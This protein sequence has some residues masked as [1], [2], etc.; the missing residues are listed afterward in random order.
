MLKKQ[1]VAQPKQMSDERLGSLEQVSPERLVFE[2]ESKQAPRSELLRELR[3]H[4]TRIGLRAIGSPIPG[5]HHRHR[6]IELEHE[7]DQ[8]FPGWR[9][10]EDGRG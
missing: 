7:L 10:S 2:G 1:V 4:E 6:I 8:S 3:M 9:G 5:N